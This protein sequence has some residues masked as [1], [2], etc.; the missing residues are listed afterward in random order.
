MKKQQM[1]MTFSVKITPH[2]S[3][4][5][6]AEISRTPPP[7][8]PNDE[9]ISHTRTHVHTLLRVCPQKRTLMSNAPL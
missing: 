6:P 7:L 5:D 9:Q 3:N 2:A 4:K 1:Q 8:S